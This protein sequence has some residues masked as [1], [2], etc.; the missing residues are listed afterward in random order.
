MISLLSHSGRADLF[1]R[2]PSFFY[3]CQNL[4]DALADAGLATECLHR[5][6]LGQNSYSRSQVFHRP[7]ATRN[8]RAWLKQHAT[9]PH[10]VRMAE[11]DDLIFD[12]DLALY[13]PAV[14]NKHLPRWLVRRR[15]RQNH[16][17]LSFFPKIS[18]STEPLAG[19]LRRC[20][21]EADVAVF[22]NC[23][24]KRW[25]HLPIPG[26][27][28]LRRRLTYFPGTRGH[29]ADFA[30]IQAPVER[31]LH[32][33]RDWELFVVGPLDFRIN[34]R[35][36]QVVRVK[37]L[38]FE[39][40]HELVQTGAINLA[41]LEPTPFNECKSALKIMEAGFFGIPTVASPIPDAQRFAGDGVEFVT[42]P[43]EWLRAM[44]SFADRF[45]YEH[46]WR[47]DLRNRVVQN[48]S[49]ESVAQRW[50]DWLGIKQ[51]PVFAQ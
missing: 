1:Q 39:R 42:T 18:T 21:P 2:D 27:S 29:N 5:S 16:R 26:T 43:E 12:A 11:V 32:G 10:I 24:P 48:A 35:A 47:E 30:M 22:P 15:F 40:Y 14:R 3:R 25:R 37:R 8:W 13:N 49:I 33:H 46:E 19:H 31:F 4:A 50:C 44:Q 36:H 34:A 20:F 23:V 6:N 41:P 38:P 28:T 45:P 17:A 7:R 9:A 51:T